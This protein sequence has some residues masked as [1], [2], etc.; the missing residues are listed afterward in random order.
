DFEQIAAFADVHR[1]CSANPSLD[2]F[3]FVNVAAKEI[4]GPVSLDEIADGSAS[5]MKSVIDP[6]ERCVVR[7]GMADQDQPVD[8]CERLE[9][10]SELLLGVCAWCVKGGGPR[11]ADPCELTSTRLDYLAMEIAEAKA[12]AKQ[13]DLVG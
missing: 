5:R 8:S 9:A 7:R 4:F 13:I 11:I 1:R 2:A 12:G 10:L 6:I 3:S